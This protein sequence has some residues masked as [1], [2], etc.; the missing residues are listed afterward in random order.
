MAIDP[1]TLRPGE[2]CRLLNST[3]LGEVISERQLHR[4]RTRAGYRVASDGDASRVD[5]LRYVAWLVTTRHEALAAS[6]E[7]GLTGYE[8]VKERARQRSIL[9][10]QSGR[11]IGDLPEVADADRKANAS[12]DFRMFCDVYFPQTF[13]LPWSDDHLKVIAKI[14]RAV[15]EGGL[16]AMAMPRGSGKTSLCETACLWA[17]LYGHREFVCLIGSD[18]DHAAGMLDS[19]KAELENND[20]LADDFPEV[21]HPIRSLDGI[22]QRAAGQLYQGT[23]THIGWT[24]KEIVLPSIEGSSASTF[25]PE[26]VVAPWA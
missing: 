2:L 22:T 1:R 24:A 8:A 3:P 9:L 4:H 7:G 13:H 5:L 6:D 16:F 20:L 12:T 11:D 19:I 25:S 26:P 23:Q 17:M 18:E 21:C 10:S 15:L 14:E